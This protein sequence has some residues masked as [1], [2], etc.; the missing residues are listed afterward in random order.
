GIDVQGT[1]RNVGILGNSIGTGAGGATSLGNG[2]DGI[3]VAGLAMNVTIGGTASGAGNLISGNQGNGIH[4]QNTT[5]PLPILGNLIGTSFGGKDAIPNAL[6]GIRLDTSSKVEIRGNTI[7][8]NGA[9]GVNL[10]NGSSGNVVAANKIGVGPDGTTQVNNAGFGVWV[11]QGTGAPSSNNTIGGTAAGD[12]NVIGS[13]AKGVVIG[14]NLMDKSQQNAILGNSIFQNP[15]NGVPDLID[16][17]NNGPTY[18]PSGT[19]GPNLL[20]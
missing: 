14:D 18:T 1:A 8:G 16:L 5:Q 2:T 17:G 10:V 15:S 19:A 7:S 12:G 13:N 20:E 4:L 3:R 6:D 11:H 9:S